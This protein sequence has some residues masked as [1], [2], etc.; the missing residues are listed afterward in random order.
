MKSFLWMI[1][2]LVFVSL[3]LVGVGIAMIHKTNEAYDRGY[4]AGID[5]MSIDK[6]CS[7]WL[8]NAN[9]KDVKQRICKK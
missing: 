5:S 8:F 3:P 7:A 1:C 9:L 2:L 4:Q 6:Q